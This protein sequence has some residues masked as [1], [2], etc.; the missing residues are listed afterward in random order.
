MIG[1]RGLLLLLLLS[2]ACKDGGGDSAPAPDGDGD[3]ALAPEDCDD[4]DGAV[5]PAAAEVCDGVDNNCD[6]WV[7][8]QDP[9]L[10]L[11]TATAWFLDLDL[12]G[13]GDDATRVLACV[14]P[15][16]ALDTGGDCDGDNSR[17]HP[18]A[19]EQCDGVDNNCDGAEDEGC[20][21]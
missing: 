1:S 18:E 12:D 2:L 16:N 21:G 7:D 13:F 19:E 5:S 15:H 10:D 20:A 14:A 3:G 11:S 4:S 9:A 8:D 17:I 6:G